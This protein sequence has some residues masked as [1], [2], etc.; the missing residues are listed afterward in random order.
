VR[1]HLLEE[2]FHVAPRGERTGRTD[3]PAL[4]HSLLS[5]T[6]RATPPGRSN[7]FAA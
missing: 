1:F 6:C 5:L 3:Q 4:D 7:L 2:G